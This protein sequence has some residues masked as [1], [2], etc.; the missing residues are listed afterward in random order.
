MSIRATR[1]W[2]FVVRLNL[3]ALLLENRLDP[4]AADRDEGALTG[5]RAG[6]PYPRGEPG[7]AANGEPSYGAATSF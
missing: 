4:R 6:A 3:L 1:A 5:W 7:G 2:P